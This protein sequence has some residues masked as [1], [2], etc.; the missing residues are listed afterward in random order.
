[1]E[2][3]T[4]NNGILKAVFLSY[5]AILHELWIK[6]KNG[7]TIDIIQGLQKPEDYLNDSW[8]RGAIIGRYAGRLENPIMIE[9][10]SISIENNQG[11]LLHSGQSGWNT[12]E[13]EVIHD[14]KPNSIR[15]KY[16]C[17]EGNSGFPGNI[18]AEI[19]YR[20]KDN[21]ICLDYFLSLIHI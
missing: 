4:L 13:W 2:T 3:F 11:V 16:R 8:S 12:K 9:E 19:N 10:K 5:G 7:S 18:E 6:N 1:M 21:R 14:K 17:N 20:L 15:F